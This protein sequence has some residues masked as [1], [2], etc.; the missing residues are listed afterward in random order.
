MRGDT[1][2]A[3][4]DGEMRGAKRLRMT[5]TTRISNGRDMIDVDA[6][7]QLAARRMP[8]HEIRYPLL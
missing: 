6:E 5:A 4:F 3:A 8:R 2:R 7:P 1:V